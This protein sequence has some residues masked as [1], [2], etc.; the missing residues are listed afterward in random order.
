MNT[1]AAM[2]LWEGADPASDRI[3]RET[4]REKLTIAFV[5]SVDDAVSVASELV[6]DGVELIE[7]CGGFGMEGG[8][9]VSRAIAGRAAVGGIAFGIE[10]LSQAAAY[11]A[12]FERSV[13]D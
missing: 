3:V 13:L 9:I 1:W 5:A 12:K 2:I 4:K 6:E 7:L 10:S 8:A 11:K